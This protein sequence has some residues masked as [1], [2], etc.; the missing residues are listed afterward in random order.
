MKNTLFAIALFGSFLCF[1][2]SAAG[3]YSLNDRLLAA[4]KAGDASAVQVLLDKGA[5]I[6]A[7][8]MDGRTA[9]IVAAV[10]GRA[11]MLELLLDK[12]ANI[13][14]T[15]YEGRTA[16]M[17]AVF[18]SSTS[19]T[20]R[21]LLE[22]GAKVEARDNNGRTA[23]YWAVSWGKGK[24]KLL[25]E[26]GADI[27]AKDKFGSTPL[28]VANQ[29]GP[30]EL[31]DLLEEYRQRRKQRERTRSQVD[32]L[33]Q[34]QWKDPQERFAAYLGVF[35]KNSKDDS[36]REKV[37]QVAN[38]LPEPPA[39]PEEARQLF[40]EASSQMKQAS[41]PAALGQPIALL[42]KT[43]AIAPWWANAYYNLSR[44]LELNGQYDEAVKQLNY[45]LKLNPSEADAREAR[46][47]IVVIQ[48]MKEAATQKR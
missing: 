19:D 12:G 14:A 6:E 20:T 1:S 24:V 22:K 27:E 40:V 33:E 16:L 23:L 39:I 21:L 38:A 25:L 18:L 10:Q 4:V 7:K 46:A 45:Y 29:S 32:Q 13:E 44:A 37:I 2:L 35:Q 26:K 36:L 9:L 47:H 17:D 48:T 31:V 41:N 3:Q 15:D 30:V 34:T 8:E 11:A 5:D 28:S 42:Q 43:V